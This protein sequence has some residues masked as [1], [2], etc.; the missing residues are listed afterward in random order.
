MRVKVWEVL[1]AEK[2]KDGSKDFVFLMEEGSLPTVI[3]RKRRLFS[4]AVEVFRIMFKN[5]LR[6]IENKI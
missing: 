5:S 3:T 1:V 2:K 4:S 6:N